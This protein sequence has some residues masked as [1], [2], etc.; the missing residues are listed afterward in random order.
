MKAVDILH[1]FLGVNGRF[2]RLADRKFYTSIVNLTSV[3]S[4]D[5]YICMERDVLDRFCFEIMPW[6]CHNVQVLIFD[7]WT[8]EDVL[9]AC[10]YPVL[11]CI[12]FTNFQSDV[13]LNC[14]K[15]KSK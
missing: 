8:M 7:H 15:G 4:I 13:I 9:L 6:I 12:I 14:L 3:S 5:Q 11:K 1:S 10:K 2:D